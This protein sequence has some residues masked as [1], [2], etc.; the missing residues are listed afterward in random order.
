[1][2]AT[3]AVGAATTPPLLYKS[4]FLFHNCYSLVLVR[5]VTDRLYSDTVHFCRGRPLH[6]APDLLPL[7]SGKCVLFVG[8][9]FRHLVVSRKL[10]MNDSVHSTGSH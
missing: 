6:S 10:P 4:L 8:Y 9:L 7:H 1:M 2:A 5:L 3:P